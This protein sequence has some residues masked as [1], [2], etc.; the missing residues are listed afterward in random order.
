MSVA[1]VCADMSGGMLCRASTCEC[2]TVWLPCVL[3]WYLIAI[4]Y[5]QTF[6]VIV[7]LLPYMLVGG[8]LIATSCLMHCEAL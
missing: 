5:L 8:G 6:L 4:A 7:M 2:T 3:A 1:L